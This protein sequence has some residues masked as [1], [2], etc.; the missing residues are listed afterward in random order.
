PANV[1]GAASRGRASME[2]RR[3]SRRERVN[4]DHATH[5][6]EGRNLQ[7][8]AVRLLTLEAINVLAAALLGNTRFPPRGQTRIDPL[9]TNAMIRRLAHLDDDHH[10]C[11]E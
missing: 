7:N 3:C 5:E 4:S 11:H 8:S 9:P 2:R 6:T 1:F 10:G